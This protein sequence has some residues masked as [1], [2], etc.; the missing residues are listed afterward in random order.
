MRKILALFVFFLA[1]LIEMS[2]KISLPP[3]FADNMVLQQCSDAALWGTAKP[4]SKVVIT[5]SWSGKKTIVRADKDGNWFVRIATPVAGGPYEIVFSDGEKFSLKNVLIGEVWICSGQSNM[6]QKMKGYEGQP[7]EGAAE[8]ISE[9]DPSVPIRICN[10]RLTRSMTPQRE[11]G[12]TWF[13]HDQTGVAMSSA[14]A[15]F[16]ALKLQ[17]L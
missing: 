11:C 7:I 16:F 4:E 13:V 5:P 15:Y 12:A 8:Y 14:V 1:A 17:Y 9:A 3:V 2:A 10:I 6:Y